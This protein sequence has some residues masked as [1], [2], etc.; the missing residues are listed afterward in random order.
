MNKFGLDID[1]AIETFAC[2]FAQSLQ[3]K[4]G[5]CKTTGKTQHSDQIVMKK[6][7]KKGRA[8]ALP[9]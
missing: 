1:S 8:Q 5:Q 4:I 6:E 7:I 2:C 9:L 3:T